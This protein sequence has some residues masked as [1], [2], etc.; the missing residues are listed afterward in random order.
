MTSRRD[1]TLAVVIAR[2]YSYAKLRYAAADVCLVL[3][4]KRDLLFLVTP[5]TSGQSFW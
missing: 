2:V 5:T 1:P 4:L 3:Y